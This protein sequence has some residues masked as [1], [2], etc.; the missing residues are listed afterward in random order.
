MSKHTQGG[1]VPAVGQGQAG[2]LTQ[3]CS[4]LR[5]MTFTAKRSHFADAGGTDPALQELS[6]VGEGSEK[7]DRYRKALGNT[8]PGEKGPLSLAQREPVGYKE[9]RRDL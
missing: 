8:G 1:Q 5:H 2:A 9:L 3:G 4:I 6:L 7:T